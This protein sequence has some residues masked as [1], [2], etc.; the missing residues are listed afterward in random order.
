MESIQNKP[1]CLGLVYERIFWFVCFLFLLF[2][3]FLGGD[4][5]PGTEERNKPHQALALV[6]QMNPLLWFANSKKNIEHHQP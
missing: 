2:S 1:Q 4:E 3:S 5:G 6:T